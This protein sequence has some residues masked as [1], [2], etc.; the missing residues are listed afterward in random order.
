MN[1]KRTFHLTSRQVLVASLLFLG[2]ACGFIG[3]FQ[4]IHFYP[5][6]SNAPAMG[7]EGTIYNLSGK[8]KLKSVG[9][10]DYA[11]EVAMVI[12]PAD[13]TDALYL[14]QLGFPKAWDVVYGDHFHSKSVLGAKLLSRGKLVSPSGN[15]LYVEIVRL[16][17]NSD[18]RIGVA[19]DGKQQIYK[20]AF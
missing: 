10:E 5:V 15:T 13:P 7:F 11:G 1:P 4:S 19:V 6:G 17:S 14:Q 12:R 16:H 20:I 18:E 2:T 8:V 9:G 3:N